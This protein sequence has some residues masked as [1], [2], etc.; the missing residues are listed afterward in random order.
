MPILL[1][2][3]PG[4]LG[5]N[6]DAGRNGGTLVYLSRGLTVSVTKHAK[7][8]DFLQQSARQKGNGFQLPPRWAASMGFRYEL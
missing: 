7:I 6:A 8:L 2:S 3:Q 4:G 5:P 1:N